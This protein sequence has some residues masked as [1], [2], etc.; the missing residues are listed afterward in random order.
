MHAGVL[1]GRNVVVET[2]A[3]QVYLAA[4]AQGIECR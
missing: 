4:S 2:V 3:V 1:G